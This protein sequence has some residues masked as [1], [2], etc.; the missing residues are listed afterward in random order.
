MLGRFREKYQNAVTP[1]GIAL[2][3][4]GISPNL[5][6]IL[7]LLSSL[8]CSYVYITKKPVYGAL[9][10]LLTGMLDMLDGAIARASHSVTRFGATFDHVMDRYAEFFI[11]FGIIYSGYTNIFSGLFTLFGMI[12]ASF[13]RAKAES[14]GG[15]KSCTVGVAERQEKLLLMIIGSILTTV[16]SYALHYAILLIGVLSHVTVIQRLYYTWI[17]TGGN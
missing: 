6:T 8:V 9:L 2:A 5:M 16:F 13:T 4:I 17:K 7:S 3:K 12:M 10:I 1:I 15:L 11:L 14:V